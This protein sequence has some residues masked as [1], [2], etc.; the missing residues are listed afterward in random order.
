MKKWL[1]FLVSA[2]LVL[3]LA[4][5][6]M[7]AVTVKGDFRY[8]FTQD[9][10]KTK[11]STFPVSDLRFSLEGPISESVTAYG[12]FQLKHDGTD[13]DT[14]KNT[15]SFDLNEYY[16][17][18]KKDWGSVK[19]GYYEYKFT[20]S[21][22][23]LKSGNKHVWDKT[24]VLIASTFKT[25]VDGFTFD[26]LYQP[27][28]QNVQDDGS[29]GLSFAYNATNFGVKFTYADF[30]KFNSAEKDLFAW[31]FYYMLNDTMKLFADAVDY[32]ENKATSKISGI[33]PVVGFA[34]DKIGGS[35]LYGAVEY[36][37]NARN[38][39]LSSEFN[40]YTI[41]L[42]YKFTDKTGLEIEHYQVAKDQTKDV[43]RLRYQF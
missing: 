5:V 10:S 36:A 17:T 35:G 23:L 9:E 21:R 37:L 43:F 28:A 16:V 22:V 7:A 14:G 32:S 1:V 30:K 41:N 34:W 8:E 33:D 24:D 26:F 29:Y 38:E 12:L 2:A 20:P 15:T 11:K 27:Y 6:S 3:S 31:D 42:K 4:A 39:N 18:Y 13:I 19:A 40:E 25:P